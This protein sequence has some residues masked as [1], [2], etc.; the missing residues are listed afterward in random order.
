MTKQPG[1]GWFNKHTE[2]NMAV[3]LGAMLSNKK[4]RMWHGHATIERLGDNMDPGAIW[5]NKQPEYDI[6]MQVGAMWFNFK[7]MNIKMQPGVQWLHQQ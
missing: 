4:T 3:Q 2:D 1:Y 5:V 6:A 7:I